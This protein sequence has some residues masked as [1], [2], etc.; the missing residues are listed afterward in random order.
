[1]V[2]KQILVFGAINIDVSITT[3]SA[4]VIGDS[5]PANMSFSVG[6][7]GANIAINLAVLGHQVEM[8][9]TF[10]DNPF[11]QFAESE[12]RDAGVSLT[13]A[14]RISD[15]P[16]NFYM[17]ILQESND[18]FLGLNDMKGINAFDH[19]SVRDLKIDPNIFDAVVLDNNLSGDVLV[20]IAKQYQSRPLFVDT[21]SLSKANKVLNVLPYLTLLKCNDMEFQHLQ[22]HGFDPL[23]YPNV[24]TV[25][26]NHEQP[27][28]VFMDGHKTEVPV[29]KIS[30]V[31]STSGAGDALLSGIIDAYVNGHDII[32]AVT[33]ATEVASK[34][35]GLRTSSLKGRLL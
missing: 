21:V 31:V 28:T 15:L 32:T 14:K 19:S 25:V 7:V 23:S 26:T 10:G 30:H 18:L 11:Y 12:L 2:A 13:Y 22:E 17:S 4:Y 1:M 34:V 8:V 33:M 3:S 5:N 16:S 20:S 9:T 35:I 29:P 27:I 24:I 6:G